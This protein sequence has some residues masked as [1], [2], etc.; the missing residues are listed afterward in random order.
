M[1]PSFRHF[2][3]FI[4]LDE[5]FDQHGF[6]KK[7]SNR[8]DDPG[9]NAFATMITDKT[10]P[11]SREQHSNSTDPNVKDVSALCQLFTCITLF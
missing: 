4:D 7:V 8:I 5:K 11:I 1:L 2:L 3:K 9:G 6:T 10:M